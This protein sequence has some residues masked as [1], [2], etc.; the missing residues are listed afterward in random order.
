MFQNARVKLTAWYL[1]IIMLISSTF[2]IIIYKGLVNEVERFER[3]Q[4]LRI[5]RR[6]SEDLFFP[7]PVAGTHIPAIIITNPELVSE[8]EQRIVFILAAVNLIILIIS[9]GFGYILAGRTLKPIKEM[10][11]EQNRFIS[12]A[13]HELKTPLTSLKSAFEV[14]LRNKKSN[15]KEAKT[16]ILEGI[17]DVNKLQSLSESLLQLAQYQKLKDYTY[18]EAVSLAGVINE[19]VNKVKPIAGQKGIEI[20]KK[21]IDMDIDGNKYS[22]VDL[23]IILLDNAIKYSPNNS[24]I[25]IDTEKKDGFAI[26]TVKD[27]GTGISENDL[28]HI[29]KRFYRSDT[30]RSK[31]QSGGY[32]LGLSIA[33]DIVILHN[34]TLK[35]KSAVN[36]GSVFMVSLPVSQNANFKKPLFFS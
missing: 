28:P 2:S 34:G 20:K 16:I 36:K 9:G 27:Q 19:A 35:A 23:I 21:T 13:S 11:D 4:R 14:F 29:F 5:E 32:G 15:L 25:L 30:A 12:D 24:E 18:F 31:N 7:Q 10:I 8:T 22:L 3:I 6:L 26:I 33:K 17:S 1:L